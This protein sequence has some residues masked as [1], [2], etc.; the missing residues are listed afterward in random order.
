MSSRTL[1]GSSSCDRYDCGW[2]N[3][4]IGYFFLYIFR[5]DIE[6]A[7]LLRPWI[8]YRFNMNL[9]VFL[10]PRR[11]IKRWW[12]SGF[13][14][15]LWLSTIWSLAATRKHGVPHIIP[16]SKTPTSTWIYVIPLPVLIQD[17]QSEFCNEF[18]LFFIH[19]NL[20]LNIEISVIQIDKEMGL[21]SWNRS[22][23][24]TG[25]SDR[26]DGSDLSDRSDISENEVSEVTPCNPVQRGSNG[27][28]N[29]IPNYK[30]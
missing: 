8:R 30:S 4:F 10:T 3:Q 26:F 22:G 29:L 1:F 7:V 15:P 20:T 25:Q 18:L 2:N 11:W 27:R 5:L 13:L 28:R 12:F 21:Y 9:L 19:L 14:R 6:C 24:R 16:C 23:Q 17:F